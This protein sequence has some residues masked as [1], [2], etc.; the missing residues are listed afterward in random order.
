VRSGA[1]RHD[2]PDA[3]RRRLGLGA[4]LVVGFGNGLAGDDGCGP[5]VI[6]RLRRRAATVGLR[7]AD[8]GTDSLRLVSLWRGEAEV[9]LVDCLRRGAPPGTVHRLEH[10]ALLELPQPH[11]SAHQLSLPENLRAI[12]HA[13]P[14]MARVRYRLWGIEPARLAPGEGLSEEVERATDAVADE[15][16]C[17]GRF[18]G[19]RPSRM[20]GGREGTT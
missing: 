7:A 20:V 10:A 1:P 2:R 18:R 9:W 13:W 8:G 4:V 11:A 15:I 16:L 12:A 6:A 14:E 5:A 3:S 19:A 17:A